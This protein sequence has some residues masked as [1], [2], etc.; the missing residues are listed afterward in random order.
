[1]SHA[2]EYTGYSFKFSGLLKLCSYIIIRARMNYIIIYYAAQCPTLA[3]PANGMVT[4]DG[5]TATYS[6]D[7]GF[8]LESAT[9]SATRTCQLTGSWTGTAPQCVRKS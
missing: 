9:G 6:C 7:P 8:D 3:S 1:M 4:I 5:N 2:T